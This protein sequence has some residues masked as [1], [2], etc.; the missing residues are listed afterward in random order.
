MAYKNLKAPKKEE[1]D[2]DLMSE[3]DLEDTENMEEDSEMQDSMDLTSIS[4]EDL[5][6]EIKARGLDVGSEEMSE[7]EEEMSEEEEELDFEEP[8]MVFGKQ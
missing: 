4:D 5:M 7:D 1:L 6:A 2:M 3:L 8:E